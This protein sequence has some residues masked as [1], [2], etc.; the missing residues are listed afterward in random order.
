MAGI[1][2]AGAPLGVL[3]RRSI[4]GQHLQGRGMASREERGWHHIG[5]MA[6]LGVLERRSIGGQHSQGRRWHRVKSV[7]GITSERWHR[8][9]CWSIGASED[10]IRKVD[11][12]IV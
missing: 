8:S 3:E 5:E 2:L 4:G 12:G 11:D 1:M 9:E 7:D 6:W 10:S